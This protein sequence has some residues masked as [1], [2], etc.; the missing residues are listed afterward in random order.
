MAVK[1][2]KA[3]C[4]AIPS[5]LLATHILCTTAMPWHSFDLNLYLLSILLYLLCLKSEVLSMVLTRGT[6]ESSQGVGRDL[7]L[8]KEDHNITP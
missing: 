7:K 4:L 2:R 8:V 3:F 5:I 6:E 1:T